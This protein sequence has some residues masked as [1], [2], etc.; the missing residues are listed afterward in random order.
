L[1][2]SPCAVPA[3]VAFDR[4]RTHQVAPAKLNSLATFHWHKQGVTACK[5]LQKGTRRKYAF[6]DAHHCPVQP[7]TVVHSI[8]EPTLLQIGLYVIGP[9]RTACVDIRDPYSDP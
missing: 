6:Q 8:S 5:G 3:D 7:Y 1:A 9:L 4:L 2:V